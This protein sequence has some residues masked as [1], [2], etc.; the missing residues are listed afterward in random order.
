MTHSS[1]TRRDF[2]NGI[3][4]EEE[5]TDPLPHHPRL[6]RSSVPAVRAEAEPLLSILA[7]AS[8]A[9]CDPKGGNR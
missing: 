4:T 7:A 8:K 9:L 2:L 1:T 3:S 5:V 6:P